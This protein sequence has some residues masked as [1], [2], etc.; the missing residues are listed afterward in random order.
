MDKLLQSDFIAYLKAL[1]PNVKDIEI[2][3]VR[4]D[5]IDD[6]KFDIQDLKSTIKQALG[7]GSVTYNNP[8]NKLIAIVDYEDFLNKQPQQP[9]YPSNKDVIKTLGL[10]KPD[11]IVYDLGI[12]SF[13]I[14]NELSQSGNPSSKQKDAM[15]QLHN[16]L[17]HFHKVTTI[18]TFIKSFPDRRCVFSNRNH[19]INS[20]DTIADPFEY[21]QKLLQP[22]IKLKFQPITKLGFELVETNVIDI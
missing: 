13:F 22:P 6:T 3:N 1:N 19:P 15:Q 16:A 2:K 10:K 7:T 18:K 14:L 4:T 11:F 17:M 8:Q 5:V 12:N 21:I 20:P 9:T